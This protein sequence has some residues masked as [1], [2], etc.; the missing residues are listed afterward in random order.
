MGLTCIVRSMTGSQTPP[1]EYTQAEHYRGGR[2]GESERE[3]ESYM[4]AV[5]S[6]FIPPNLLTLP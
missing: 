6:E 2:E 1:S 3:R 5:T 4:S